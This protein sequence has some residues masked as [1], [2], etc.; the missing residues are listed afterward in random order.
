MG[1]SQS[2]LS[3]LEAE[4]VYWT[5]KIITFVRMKACWRENQQQPQISFGKEVEAILAT[6][7]KAGPLFP[8]L[9]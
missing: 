7:P 3:H 8:Y 5:A 4:D 1:A 2:D 9:S 6:R